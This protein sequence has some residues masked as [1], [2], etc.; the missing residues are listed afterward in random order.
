AT[1]RR[2]H[3]RHRQLCPRAASD[4]R[5]PRQDGGH[6]RRVDH[7]ADRDQGAA[8]RPE[9][10]DDRHPRGRGRPQ[11]DRGRRAHPQGHRADRR[12]DD[13]AGDG[14]PEHRLL[15]RG[16][17]GHPRRAGVRHVGRLLGVHLRAGDRG[18]LRPV[19]AVQARP[20]DRVR[21]DQPDRQLQGPGQL[22]PVRRRGRG[23]GAQPH[24]GAEAG[25]AVQLDA[26]RRHR[27][28]RDEVRPG[29]P[30]PGQRA[31]AGRGAAVHADPRPRGVQVRGHEVRGADPRRDG[32][33]RADGRPGQADRPAPGEPADHRQR[34]GEAR[35][36]VGQGV[37]EHR[38]VRQHVGRQH[39]ARARR[40]VAGGQGAAGRP[41]DLRRVRGGPDLGKR[42]V[43]RL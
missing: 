25:D 14:V 11:G 20:G 21:D 41:R 36:D 27:R 16:R 23:R 37:R 3:H 8:D 30:V 34:D 31:D 33:V 6:E 40:G 29:Q 2:E 38:A 5:R 24:D 15:H 18:E 43:P 13:H 32:Q 7:P 10:R 19:R 42:R 26:R 12:R 4:Q 22:H 17:A 35:A 1:L 9:R 28:G 39:P